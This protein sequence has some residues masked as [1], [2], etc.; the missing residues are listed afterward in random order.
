MG[1]DHRIT[2]GKDNIKNQNRLKKAAGKSQVPT[3]WRTPYPCAR[4]RKLNKMAIS[5]LATER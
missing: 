4:I 1:T 2:R 5:L 3:A